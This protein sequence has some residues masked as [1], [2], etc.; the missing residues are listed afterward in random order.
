MMTEKRL[1]KLGLTQQSMEIIFKRRYCTGMTIALDGVMI[2]VLYGSIL[3]GS[4]NIDIS[5]LTHIYKEG[6]S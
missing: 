4:N 6:I 3:I 1:N 2:K 5:Q